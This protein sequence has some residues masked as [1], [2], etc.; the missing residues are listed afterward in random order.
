MNNARNGLHMVLFEIETAAGRIDINAPIPEARNFVIGHDVRVLKGETVQAVRKRLVE[1]A[2]A[3]VARIR[4]LDLA[5]IEA[6]M[7]N[8]AP[9]G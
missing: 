3:D 1:R 9:R 5:E 8:A 7:P 6:M 4:Q 2:A